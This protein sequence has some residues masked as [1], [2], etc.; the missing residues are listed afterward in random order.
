MSGLGGFISGSFFGVLV[1]FVSL[2]LLTVGKQADKHMLSPQEIGDLIDS[3]R[4]QFD[5]KA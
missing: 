4:P 3:P 2:A 1:M 5:E